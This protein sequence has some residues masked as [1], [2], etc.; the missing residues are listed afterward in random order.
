MEF[1]TAEIKNFTHI[2]WK[3]VILSREDRMTGT[4]RL[5]R[6]ERL[7]GRTMNIPEGRLLHPASD[8]LPY[9]GYPAC[10]KKA[11]GELHSEHSHWRE[12]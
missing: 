12:E 3:N 7:A 9:Q 1:P 11:S 2:S 6:P 5:T 10:R 8:Q 4:T